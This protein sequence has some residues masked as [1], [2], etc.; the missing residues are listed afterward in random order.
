MVILGQR[1]AE[2]YMKL[3]PDMRIQVTAGGFGN[4]HRGADQ[5]RDGCAVSFMASRMATKLERIADQA[6]NII[7]NAH[8]MLKATSLK[9]M[10]VL[11]VMGEVVERMVRDSL[12]VLV[13]KDCSMASENKISFSVI[14]LQVISRR[15]LG[16]SCETVLLTVRSCFDSR[17]GA[18]SC[19]A[20]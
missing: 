17:S 2:T 15:S 10:V 5:R 16:C 8:H 1:W 6:V 12:K 13:A 11:P 4:R 3:H 20:Y 18:L 14:C 7:Q 9:P 19:I